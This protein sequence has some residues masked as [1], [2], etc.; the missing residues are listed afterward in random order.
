MKQRMRRKTVKQIPASSRLAL[1]I[2]TT[3]VRAR[4]EA[5]RALRTSR[6]RLRLWD[7]QHRSKGEVRES[8]QQR[9]RKIAELSNKLDKEAIDWYQQNNP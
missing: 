1:L 3:Q 2:H 7:K 6:S 4:R 8:C 5:L 9:K